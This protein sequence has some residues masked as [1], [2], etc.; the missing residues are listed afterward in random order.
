M[1]KQPCSATPFPPGCSELPQIQNCETMSQLMGCKPRYPPLQLFEVF[2]H[3]GWKLRNILWNIN[4][5]DIDHVNQMVLTL[6]DRATPFVPPTPTL[7]NPHT[8]IKK[9][10]VWIG[11]S[12]RAFSRLFS[13]CKVSAVWTCSTIWKDTW[14]WAINRF[15][16]SS[17]KLGRSKRGFLF[18]L[19]IKL[20]LKP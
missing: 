13:N 18:Y 19:L 12:C 14:R 2:D 7:F 3:N 10:V 1:S 15:R 8:W 17:A 11:Y 9:N 16:M 20:N 4:W 6:A 5:N